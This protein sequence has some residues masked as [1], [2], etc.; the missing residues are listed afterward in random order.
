MNPTRRVEQ[1]LAL[2]TDPAA[3]P[4][5]ART[6]ALQAARNIRQHGLRLTAQRS[7]DVEGRSP[8][9]NER[10]LAGGRGLP[11][12]PSRPARIRELPAQ[13]EAEPTGGGVHIVN[14]DFRDSELPR[15]ND[16]A[17]PQGLL[18]K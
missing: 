15:S 8:S 3:S 4:E 18:K 13:D 10:L 9:Q 14:F 2:A 7:E 6:A 12:R 5:E 11:P 1:L 16:Y 17:F